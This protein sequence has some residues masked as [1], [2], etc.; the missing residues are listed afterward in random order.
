MHVVQQHLLRVDVPVLHAR[1]RYRNA[2]V[3]RDLRAGL[4]MQ[5]ASWGACSP[6]QAQSAWI[7]QGDALCMYSIRLRDGSRRFQ[8]HRPSR[9][10]PSRPWSIPVD[11]HTLVQVA[12]VLDPYR[13]IPSNLNLLRSCPRTWNVCCDVA[14]RR[15][16]REIRAVRYVPSPYVSEL[17]QGVRSDDAEI[18]Q[19]DVRNRVG[20]GL[21]VLQ[22]AAR[23]L[24]RTL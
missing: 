5:H 2:G 13:P 8:Y 1:A 15:P 14:L 20:W 12:A 6:C 23:R 17:Q 9:L 22:R 24:S 16:G 21:G 18:T 10:H 4:S 7:R 3:Q 19:T 11:T